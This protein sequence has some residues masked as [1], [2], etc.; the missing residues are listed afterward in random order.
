MSDNQ[1]GECGK[2]ALV[3]AAVAGYL[4]YNMSTATEMPRQA[5][6]ILQYFLLTCALIALAGSLVKLVSQN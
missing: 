2:L 1:N 3:N 5:L 4:I 6:L